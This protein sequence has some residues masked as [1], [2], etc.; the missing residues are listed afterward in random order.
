MWKRL[1]DIKTAAT[2][3]LAREEARNVLEAYIYRVRDMIEGSSFVEAS[4]ESER[5]VIREK[6]EAANEWLWDEA[7]KA[8]TNDLK[9]KKRELE[10]VYPLSVAGL[11]F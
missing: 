10:H 1:R 11:G 2:R 9:D 3:K 8:S 4:L 5:K 7:D 6:N